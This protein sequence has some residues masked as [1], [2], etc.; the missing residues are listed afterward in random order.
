M[1]K[2]QLNTKLTLDALDIPIK[3]GSFDQRLM[4]QKSIYLAKAAGHDCGYYFRWY[5]RG[6]YSPDL[7][8]DVF[9]IVAELE[10][11]VDESA[12]WQLDAGSVQRLSGLRR[13]IPPYRSP[14]AAKELE[15]LASV[16]FL[17]DQKQVP[18]AD[19]DALTALLKRYGKGSSKDDIEKALNELRENELLSH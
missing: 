13:L 5:L 18:D 3:T 8:R 16:H 7:T 4:T 1:N 6:P 19:S 17:V 11:G 12:D 14:G 9:S 2:Q 15:L 10:S